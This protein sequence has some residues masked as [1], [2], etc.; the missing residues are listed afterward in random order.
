MPGSTTYNQWQAEV[1]LLVSG[2]ST[3]STYLAAELPSAIDYAEGR[4]YR[5][6]N[7]LETVTADTSQSTV[8]SNRNVAIPTDF[9]V[10]NNIN[11]VTPPGNM[12]SVGTR[13]QLVKSSK[14]VLD[15]LWPS[16]AILGVPQRFAFLNTGQI[17]LGPWPDNAY[18]VE[19]EGTQR[20]APLSSSNQ[21]TF[22][23]LNM[24]DL[25]LVATM[26]H[27]S[28]FMKNFGSQADNPQQAVSWETQYETLARGVDGEELRRRW[29]NTSLLPRAGFDNMRPPPM[30][31]RA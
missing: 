26:I 9:I 3:P 16:P 5:E 24:P 8:T 25:F 27:I 31:M 19:F 21:T 11:I 7:F 2:A 17:V 28:G 15:F 1:A 4:I 6:F 12:P 20:P 18:V 10:I 13:N 22:I 30:P 14:A 29:A 23:S